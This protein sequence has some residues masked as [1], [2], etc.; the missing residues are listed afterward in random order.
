ME[1]KLAIDIVTS[2][3]K[4]ITKLNLEE[5]MMFGGHAAGVCYN[6]EGFG[7]VKAENSEVTKKRIERTL[8]SGH[9]SVYDHINITFNIQ[10]ISKMLAMILNNENQYST[11]EKSSRYTPIIRTDDSII[12]LKEEELYN[13]WHG[14]LKQEIINLYKGQY[15]ETKADNLAKENARYMVTVF[16][17]TQMLY[18]TS[19]R[20]INLLAQL[21]EEYIEKSNDNVYFEK[22]LADE[23]RQFVRELR[24]INVIV[25]ELMRNEKE[26]KISLFGKNLDQKEE[27]F[28]DVY[29]TTYLGTNAQLAQAHR[30]RTL[31]YEME[32]LEEKQYF[33]PPII[34]NNDELVEDWLKDIRSVAHIIPQGELVRIYESGNIDNFILKIKE[35]LCTYAQLEIMKQS[36]ATLKKMAEELKIKN[37]P[38]AKEIEM[39]TKG[40]RCTF[41]DYTCLSQCGFNEGVT[42]KRRI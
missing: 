24:R 21:M 8:S 26:R 20:Q 28:G 7:T 13:K 39:Y 17:P 4:S 41:P 35:R 30:H 42:L 5:A 27:Y 14:I 37:H 32:F 25:P 29:S 2:G 9:T 12:T 31:D 22:T 3:K 34:K 40:A 11:S 6:K 18:T 16:M 19:L 33:I 23:M 10:N 15:P 1:S 38:R 36:S